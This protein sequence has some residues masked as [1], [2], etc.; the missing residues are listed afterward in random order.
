[1]TPVLDPAQGRVLLDGEDVA[2]SRHMPACTGGVLIG[3]WFIRRALAR[4]SER[5]S[6]ISLRK[7]A[8][9]AC[10][11]RESRQAAHDA[12]PSQP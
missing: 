3:S 9:F 5:R 8:A 7:T 12:V 4:R 1:V 10:A 2:M 6:G 11:A